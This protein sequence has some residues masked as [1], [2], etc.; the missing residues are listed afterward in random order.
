MYKYS[1]MEVRFSTYK[2]C[3][4][5]IQFITLGDLCASLHGGH[6]T[7]G[8]KRQV[9]VKIIIKLVILAGML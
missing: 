4:D 5:I 7:W 3:G 2:F 9:N 8:Q 6:F 1:H